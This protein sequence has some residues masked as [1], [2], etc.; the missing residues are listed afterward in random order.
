MRPVPALLLAVPA[1]VFLGWSVDPRG[2]PTPAP[3]L[4]HPADLVNPLIGTANEGQTF[5]VAG[6]PFAMTDW[7]PQTR[8]G[9]S[10]C[11]APYYSADTRIQGFRGS[12]WMSGSCTQD[13]GSFTVMPESGPTRLAAVDRAS[14]FDHA[15][16]SARPYLYAVDLADYGIHAE[17]TGT[18]RA[19]I[20][21][22]RY[23]QP[24]P[25]RLVLQLNTRPQT[26]GA[27]IHVDRARNEVWGENPAYRL[28]AGLGKPAGFSGYFVAQFDHPIAEADPGVTQPYTAAVSFDSAAGST[29]LVRIG[30]SF[31]SVDEARA[32]LA[33]EIPA[34]NFSSTLGS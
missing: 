8:D 27:G 11:I 32:N 34:F 3:A 23:S 16:E 13:Y 26:T 12:H 20:M 30:T 24:G 19:G 4:A 7:T 21:R 15:H 2:G 29:L 14:T 33:A 31:T 18:A 6:V 10:K 22:F 17:M 9:E 25:M 5:P 1:W 28:Y